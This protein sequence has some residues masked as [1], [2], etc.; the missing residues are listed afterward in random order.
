MERKYL[1]TPPSVSL[2]GITL[3]DHVQTY[4]LEKWR[5][6]TGVNQLGFTYIEPGAGV[7]LP[8]TTW[9]CRGD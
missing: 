4:W 3:H 6:I 5:L 7:D 9:L 8:G 2:T 1:P